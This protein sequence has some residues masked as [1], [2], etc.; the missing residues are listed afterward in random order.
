MTM[1]S[2]PVNYIKK[3]NGTTLASYS[4]IDSQGYIR[5]YAVGYNNPRYGLMQSKINDLDF[6]AM[7]DSGRT[8][9]IR[10]KGW[11]L[12]GRLDRIKA[13]NK[14]GFEWNW[15]DPERTERTREELAKYGWAAMWVKKS[16]RECWTR[17]EPSTRLT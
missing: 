12:S 15:G 16:D 6:K 8:M 9:K 10:E 2:Y 3:D 11:G 4:H 5:K 1:A 7:F 14:L 17:C 13:L